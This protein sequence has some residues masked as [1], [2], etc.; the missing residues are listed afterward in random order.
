MDEKNKRELAWVG[1]AVLALYARQWILEQKDIAI[2]DRTSAFIALTSNDFLSSFGEPTMV[3]AMIGKV[4]QTEGLPQAF[5][6]IEV[7]YLP[8]YLKQR[9][10]REKANKGN[11]R[12]C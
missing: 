7:K 3:E 9:I 5:D 12:K 4:Y 8:T 1:D 6:W 2:D 11:K 10:N